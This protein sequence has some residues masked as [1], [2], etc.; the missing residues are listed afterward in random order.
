MQFETDKVDTEPRLLVKFCA[1]FP[2]VEFTTLDDFQISEFLHSYIRYLRYPSIK[3]FL[4]VEIF[5]YFE[6]EISFLQFGL[7]PICAICSF[8]PLRL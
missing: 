8:V 3:S 6:I 7:A 2:Q 5:K 1:E 4:N